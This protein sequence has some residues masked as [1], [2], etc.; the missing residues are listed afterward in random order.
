MMSWANLSFPNSNSP[1]MEQLIF[2]H[3]HSMTIIVLITLI[4]LYMIMNVI[5]NSMTSRFLMEGQEIETL[6]TIIPAVILIY[7]ALPS[8]RLLYLMEES[9]YP[10]IS[11]K[12]IGHQ[13]YWS[14]EYPD[15]NIELDSFMI[16]NFEEN[17]STFRLLD[18]DNRIVLPYNTNM[19]ILVTSADVIHSWTIPTLGVKMDAVPG[20]LNQISTLASRPGIFYGQCSEICGAN[21]SFMPISMEVTSLNNF[22]NWIKLS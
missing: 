22:L 18:V 20:R 15:F 12:V 14:Y 4:T 5:L 19:R 3:D 2:F 1:I 9:F 13:W 6:W 17:P 8:L 16:P 11:M 7:I 10:S 21:H